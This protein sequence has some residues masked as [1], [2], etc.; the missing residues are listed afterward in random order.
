[1]D[2]VEIQRLKVVYMAPD[3]APWSQ[4]TNIHDH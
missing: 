4:M 2:I 1:M 3:C